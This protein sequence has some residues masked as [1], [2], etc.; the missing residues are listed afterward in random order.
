MI[1]TT[2]IS[3]ALAT[4]G[5]VAAPAGADLNV[6][7]APAAMAPAVHT[8]DVMQG[9]GLGMPTILAELNGNPG[10]RFVLSSAVEG[11]APVPLAT[12]R[13]DAH[14]HKSLNIEIPFQALAVDLAFEARFLERRSLVATADAVFATDGECFVFDFED[15]SCFLDGNPCFADGGVDTVPGEVITDQWADE[16]QFVFVAGNNSPFPSHPDAAVIF[17]SADPSGDDFDLASPATGGFGGGVDGE[18]PDGGGALPELPPLQSPEYG[19]VLIVQENDAGCDTGV[20]DEADDENAGGAITFFRPVEDG[21]A[22]GQNLLQFN[23]CSMDLLDVDEGFT[24]VVDSDGLEFVEDIAAVIFT[25][26]AIDTK[27][28]KTLTAT[29]QA[30]LAASGIDLDARIAEIQGEADG[31]TFGVI[32]FILVPQGNDNG[33]ERVY[34][35]EQPVF[36][37]LV[38][39][40][41]SGAIAE[42]EWTPTP[43]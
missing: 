3:L 12:G 2:L 33:W 30:V 31:I 15:Y 4:G 18:D 23:M 7:K 5:V 25:I 27:G 38:A 17:D 39:F 32:D 26:G 22:F 35:S 40:F 19:R 37:T 6:S 16:N 34:F 29:E 36:Q 8:L 11:L 42:F 28:Q 21:G 13:L 43:Q 20:C 10:D 1:T 41:G 9:P 14:G 24:V